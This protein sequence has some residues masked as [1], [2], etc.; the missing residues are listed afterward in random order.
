VSTVD[1]GPVAGQP[2]PVSPAP[3]QQP[4]AVAPAARTEPAAAP[5]PAEQLAAEIVPL[6]SRDGE[7]KLTVH[8]HP[9]D[10]GPITVTAQV[11]GNDIQLD[12]GGATEGAR[13]ALRAALPELRRELER[14]GFD[15][16]LLNTGTGGA[17]EDRRPPH[18]QRPA[19]TEP[20][21]GPAAPEP[22]AA[23]PVRSRTAGVLDLHA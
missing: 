18:W 22:V 5:P 17:R 12:L 6:R 1:G 15:S 13:E 10:L 9:V 20:L 21:A 4:A 14:A 7:H 2:L 23:T 8:L 3:A 11:R 16:C 19:A